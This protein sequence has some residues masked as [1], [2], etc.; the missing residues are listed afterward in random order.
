MEYNVGIF[1]G[2][3]QKVA[4]QLM[5]STS[6]LEFTKNTKSYLREFN[7]KIVERDHLWMKENKMK[8]L[9]STSKN[10]NEFPV[11]LEI[12]FNIS[13]KDIKKLMLVGKATPYESSLFPLSDKPELRQ[14]QHRSGMGGASSI[15]GSLYALCKLQALVQIHCI[16]AIVSNQ[17]HEK[18]NKKGNVTYAM[19]GT[20]IEI[21]SPEAE[22]RLIMA[23][24][25]CYANTVDSSAIIDVTTLSS[26]LKQLIFNSSN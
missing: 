17:L 7:I 20:S 15:V 12:K 18:P 11:I 1:L 13:S 2:Q 6:V 24:L 21:N 23:D 22:G 16:I 8:S 5:K 10:S 9:L 25:L 14:F 3:G 26:K 19:N 4:Q